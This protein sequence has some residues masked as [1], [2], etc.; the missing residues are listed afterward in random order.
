MN[1]STSRQDS[2]FFP[3]SA[4]MALGVLSGCA[5]APLTSRYVDTPK[6][7]AV[8]YGTPQATQYEL[9]VEPEHE[10]LRLYLYQ[11]SECAKIPVTVMHRREEFLRDGEVVEVKEVGPVQIAQAPDGSMPC[12]AGYGRD[13]EVSLLIGGASYA[14]GATDSYGYLSVDLASLLQ[15]G[16]RAEALPAEAE[17]SIR[18]PYGGAAQVIGKVS[19]AQLAVHEQEVEK[20][21]SELEAI[22]G[23]GSDIGAQDIAR[24]YVLYEKLRQLAPGDA[25]FRAT[26][27]RFWE[28]FFNRKRDEATERLQRNLKALDAAKDLLKGASLAAIPI[29]AR[30]A[31][32]S[33]VVDPRTLEWSE[34]QLLT[35]LRAH[36]ATCRA[37]F[38]FDNL[39][40]YGFSPG[41]LFAVRYLQFSYGDGFAPSIDALCGR[42]FA[43]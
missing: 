31:A 8:E 40:G 5:S 18:P 38:R 12:E 21:L 14:L 33:G 25:R 26:A 22:L 29:F 1:S 4:L 3:A 10:T 13:V 15:R 11:Y 19:L 27:A 32:N 37:E 43:R 16:T 24:S 17:V 30:A 41:T 9:E 6:G 36:P 39:D 7:T 42:L 20:L 23:K 35:G 28:L 2:R 34:W